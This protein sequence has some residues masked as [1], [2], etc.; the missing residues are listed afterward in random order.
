MLRLKEPNGKAT[1]AIAL[2]KGNLTKHP[3]AIGYRL[4]SAVENP[5]APVVFWTGPIDL[6][7]DQLIGADGAKVGD[8]RKN[9]PARRE[10]MELIAEMLADGPMKMG[11]V[12][13]TIKA[14]AGCSTKTIRDAAKELRIVKRR[15]YVNGKVDHWTWEL[16]PKKLK[17]RLVEDGG[18]DGEK[19]DTP[20][21]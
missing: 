13:T 10:A 9:A 21:T 8:A 5:D 19:L 17:L 1:D 4:D 16:P 2:T 7:A 12:E 6:D 15:V 3:S 11:D 20:Y 18:D 14:N